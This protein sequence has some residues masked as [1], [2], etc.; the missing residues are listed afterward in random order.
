MK[1]RTRTSHI[2]QLD[3]CRFAGASLDNRAATLV[4]FIQVALGN[5]ARLVKNGCLS[6][7]YLP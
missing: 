4:C 5:Q 6:Y 7:G 2:G 3:R 1:L